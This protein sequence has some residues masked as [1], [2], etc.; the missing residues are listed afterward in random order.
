MHKLYANTMDLPEGL[1]HLQI[2]LLAGWEVLEPITFVHQGTTVF[3][4][5]SGRMDK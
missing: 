1:E 4:E 5:E 3:E 2:L